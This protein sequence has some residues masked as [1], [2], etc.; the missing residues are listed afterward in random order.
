MRI[1]SVE[2]MKKIENL[3]NDMGLD[4]YQMMENAGCACARFIDRNIED[5]SSKEVTVVCGKGKNGGDGFVIARKMFENGYKIKVVLAMGEPKADDS[6]KNY[7]KV[8][9]LNI[10][11]ISFETKENECVD[12]IRSSDVIVDSIFG[13]GFKGK[14][15]KNVVDVF[16]LMSLSKGIVFSIDVPSGVD[17]DTG[18]VA[19]ECVKADYT[20]AISSLKPAHVLQPSVDFCGKTAIVQIGI[21]EECFEMVVENYFTAD[22]KDVSKLFSP[23]KAISN[24]G[25]C[26]KV[27]AICGS[28]TMPGAASFCANACVRSGAGLVTVAFPDRAYNAI[29]PHLIEPIL[30][31]VES[32]KQGTFAKTSVP[33]LLMAME[34]ADVIVVGCGI[35]NNLDTKYVVNQVIT[36]ANCPI[37]IDADGIN[38][39]SD[40]IDVLRAAKVPIILTP[41]PGEMARLCDKSIEEVQTDRFETAKSFAKKYGVTVVLKGSGTVVSS[42]EFTGTYINRTGNAGMATGGSGDVLS[43]IIASMLAQDLSCGSSAI[44]GV[45]IHG[46]AGD[47]C[48]KKLSM[49]GMTPSDIIKELPLL[50]SKFE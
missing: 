13:F 20:V 44:A 8:K 46:M 22:I 21:Q 34:K 10:P 49:R 28:Y 18:E 50:L 4:F 16:K 5:K 19:G 43:G 1:L 7:E 47:N 45:Y 42:P 23:R 6:I 40:N 26:G 48:A 32:N 14:P 37:I 17:T 35:G 11:I 9:K 3:A 31:P 12:V 30:L 33:R 39:I 25:D 2:Q 41:H 24:K 27:L 38:V 29:T 36:N 15:K